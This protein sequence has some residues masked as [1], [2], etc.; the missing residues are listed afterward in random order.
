MAGRIPERF[1]DE[2]LAR[3]DIVDIVDARVPLKRAGKEHKACCPFHDEK[4]PSFTVSADKQFYH[5]FGCGAHGSAIGFLME[6]EHLDFRE[7][8]ESLA[9]HVGLA[10]PE[11]AGYD[12]K[13]VA[14]TEPL[15]EILKVADK[16]YR[17]QL[18]DPE[19]AKEAVDYLKDRGL[20][21]ETAAQYGVGYAPN[22]WDCLMKQLGADSKQVPLLMQAGLITERKTGGYYDR[23]RHRIMFPI[24]DRRGRVI[25][26]GG[27]A[28]G[29]D[30]PDVQGSTSGAGDRMSGAAKYLNSPETPVFHKGRELYGWPQAQNAMHQSKRVLVVEGYMDVLAL[31][32]Y[33][34]Q[35]VVATLGTAATVDHVE[36]LFRTVPEIVFCFDGDRAGRQAAWRA[37]E[38]VMPLMRDGRQASF[39]FLPEGE[40]PDS[41]VR[42]EGQ[43]EF[44]DRLVKAM[45][46]PDYF[47]SELQSQ[48]DMGRADG[49]A[50]FVEKAQGMLEKL[51][52]GAFKEIQFE[53]LGLLGH[54]VE[55]IKTNALN[56]GGKTSTNREYGRSGLVVNSLVKQAV[57]LLVHYPSVASS[58]ELPAPWAEVELPGMTLLLELIGAIQS[59]AETPRTAAIIERF[60]DSKY[61]PTLV[62]LATKEQ[63][64]DEASAETEFNGVVEQF[65]HKRHNAPRQQV[66]EFKERREGL[67][68]AEMAELRRLQSAQSGHVDNT[69]E[70]DESSV[71]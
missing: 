19:L 46:L 20:S 63:M 67:N 28:F 47:F 33:G 17:Q 8:V 55:K 42:K 70:S 2:L 22:E 24:Q 34:I 23:F 49:R 4:T 27:R 60:R 3:A 26:F 1:I 10:M 50:R 37:L 15:F 39:L 11:D 36:K 6:Y 14:R 69:V 12:K 18:R 59:A 68:Q 61:Y 54:Q 41:M 64:L 9:S 48:V 31:A 35:Y 40:D 38:Q 58:I 30:E 44:E 7:A 5:C 52:E 66:L 29:D 51:P 21:G 71:S 53:R 16:F 43:E 65:L 57:T 32:Q 56:L 25:G 45:P 13:A 62:K